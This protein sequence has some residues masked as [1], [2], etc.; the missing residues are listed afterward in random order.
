MKFLTRHMNCY[1]W[2]IKLHCSDPLL[3]QLPQAAISQGG[4]AVGG[5]K[6]VGTVAP[7]G[8]SEGAASRVTVAAV[9]RCL[10]VFAND[11]NYDG[12]QRVLEVEVVTKTCVPATHDCRRRKKATLWR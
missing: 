12:H 6:F 2:Y 5:V 4:A 10:E 8:C 1:T 9:P 11:G 7:V 3:F